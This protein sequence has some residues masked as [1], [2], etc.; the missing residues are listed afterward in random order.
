MSFIFCQIHSHYSKPCT[1]K[2]VPFIAILKAVKFYSPQRSKYIWWIATMS[3]F[4]LTQVYYELLKP[5]RFAV[6][7]YEATH[8]IVAV[9]F[10][11]WVIFAFHNLRS[12][13][14][15][16]WLFSHPLWQPI[17]R[18]S[19]SIYL[20]HDIYII[21]SVTNLKSLAYFDL[22]WFLHIVAGD[23]VIS[24]IL[25]SLLFLFIEVPAGKLLNHFFK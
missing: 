17:A 11:G 13:T 9:V 14:V 24:T 22:S 10:F 8:R 18:L 16:R 25:A 7:F 12:G 23:L 5:Q 15:F 1:Y 3:A 20:V 21:M 19:L 4:I 2:K 6:A